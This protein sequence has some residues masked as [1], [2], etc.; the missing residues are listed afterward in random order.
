MKLVYLANN[1]LGHHALDIV[2]SS[3]AEIVALVLNPKDRRKWGDELNAA[4]GLPA[5]RVFDGNDLSKRQVID[6]ISA[7]KP[8]MALSVLFGC[9]LKKRF[10]DIFPKGVLNLHTSLLPHN[11]GAH[12]N[13]W[14][15][16][17]RTPAGVTLHYVDSGVDTG[18]IVDQQQV[19][20]EPTDTGET[21]YN[22]LER[23]AYDVL[24]RS[25]PAVVEGIGGRRPQPI[26]GSSHKVVDISSLDVVDLDAQY[27]ARDLINLLRA[28]T[29]PPHRGAYFVHEG[30]RVYLKLELNYEDD[31]NTSR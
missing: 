16:I 4:A 31:T 12:P 8:D 1:R 7:L 6:A 13:I 23:C 15:I 10:I 14:S 19:D 2:K 29:F 9:I 11:R 28:R 26:G 17:D 3:G 20:V 27:N 21:L 24:E 30:R 5:D 25:W 18:E 22:K